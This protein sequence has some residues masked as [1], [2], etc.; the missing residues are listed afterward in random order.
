MAESCAALFGAILRFGLTWLRYLGRLLR[1]RILDRAFDGF[2]PAFLHV[3]SPCLV[4][5]GLEGLIAGLEE[6][7]RGG[8]AGPQAGAEAGEEG[9]AESRRSVWGLRWIGQAEQVGLE[10]EERIG[11]R[12]TAIHADIREGGAQIFGHGVD[13]VGD[14]ERHAFERGSGEVGDA[15]GTSQPEDRAPSSGLPVGCS[16]AR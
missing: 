5:V 15:G 11:P 4:A 13:Q 8:W 12:H 10:V 3:I 16:Q 9:G 14:L 6:R 7:D 2:P 1:V